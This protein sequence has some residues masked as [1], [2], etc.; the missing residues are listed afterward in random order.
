[1]TLRVLNPSG[2][3]ATRSVNQLS[4]KLD[5]LIIPH[6]E[7]LPVGWNFHKQA[8]HAG[9]ITR[10]FGGCIVRGEEYNKPLLYMTSLCA[11]FV[12]HLSLVDINH[13]SERN[14]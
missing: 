2:V 8:A 7:R 11:G 1:M 4:A 9:K 5:L 6:I 13:F 12:Q 10:G 14:I 3:S